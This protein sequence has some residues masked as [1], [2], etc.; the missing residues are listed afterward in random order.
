MAPAALPTALGRIEVIA[1][2][3]AGIGGGGRV[4]ERVEFFV[5]GRRVK[6]VEQSP[7]YPMQLML[8]LYEFP[9]EPETEPSPEAYPNRVVVDFVQGFRSQR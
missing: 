5:D 9:A 2:L 8:I 6:A 4:T 7:S 3:V 1:I